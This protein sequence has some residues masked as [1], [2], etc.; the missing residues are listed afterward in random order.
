[1]KDISSRE[2]VELLVRE[3]YGKVRK[4]ELLDHIFDEVVKIDWEHHI[5]ILID[6]WESILLDANKYNRNAMGVHFEI[7]QKIKLEPLHFATWLSLFDETVDEYFTGEIALLA[8]TRAH[9]I[10]S[11]MEF[12]MQQINNG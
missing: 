6:F 11:I 1:M 8:K 5:P 3:F 12:K 9:S 2:D 10:A 7:N 4:N